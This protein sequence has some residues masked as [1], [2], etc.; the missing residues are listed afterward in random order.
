M[1][2]LLYLLPVLLFYKLTTRRQRADWLIY[3]WMFILAFGA[4]GF[5]Y[6]WISTGQIPPPVFAGGD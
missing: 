5:L 4:C 1:E 3:F 6:S 2:I